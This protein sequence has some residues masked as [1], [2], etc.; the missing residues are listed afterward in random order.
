MNT[1]YFCVGQVRNNGAL[2][3]ILSRNGKACLVN[4]NQYYFLIDVHMAGVYSY[5]R[6]EATCMKVEE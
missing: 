1:R 4:Y 5:K 3:C 2:L 6:E